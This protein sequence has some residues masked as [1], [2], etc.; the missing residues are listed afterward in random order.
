MQRD[1]IGMM[2]QQV[3]QGM[4]SDNDLAARMARRHIPPSI[5]SEAFSDVPPPPPRTTRI[6][7]LRDFGLYDTR[8]T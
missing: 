1:R 6:L 2:Q 8:T 7:T 4:G 5:S 3:N